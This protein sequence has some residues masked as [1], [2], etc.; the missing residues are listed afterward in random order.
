MRNFKTILFS[1]PFDIITMSLIFMYLMPFG[2]FSPN[3]MGFYL[4]IF[5]ATITIFLT[6]YLL[7]KYQK[8]LQK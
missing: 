8:N 4:C 6:K 2:T 7:K 1:V 3:E 5:Q